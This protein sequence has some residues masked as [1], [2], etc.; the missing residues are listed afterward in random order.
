M[1][2]DTD[3]TYELL[4]AYL[5]GELD[6]PEIRRVEDLLQS[7]PDA[8]RQFEELLT[9]R[10]ALLETNAPAPIGLAESIIAKARFAPRQKLPF[11]RIAFFA[12]SLLIVLSASFFVLNDKATLDRKVTAHIEKAKSGLDLDAADDPYIETEQ[13]E[14][15]DDGDR[16]S[17]TEGG[18]TSSNR[19]ED[20]ERIIG[21]K[22]RSASEKLLEKK[23]QKDDAIGAPADKNVEVLKDDPQ[24]DS[25]MKTEEPKQEVQE[26]APPGAPNS[27]APAKTAVTGSAK[28]TVV[29]QPQP[30]SKP[31]SGAG[32][33]SDA[34]SSDDKSI[35]DDGDSVTKPVARRGSSLPEWGGIAAISFNSQ[36]RLLYLD[37]AL[38]NTLVFKGG[39]AT[40]KAYTQISILIPYFGIIALEPNS[41]L[42]VSVVKNGEFVRALPA[43]TLESY[44]RDYE[45][46]IVV[47]S[48]NCSF[49]P[50]EGASSV[51]SEKESLKLAF[52][53][54]VIK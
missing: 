46:H 16:S 48:G 15:S 21:G 30:T 44:A 29:A 40:I 42:I 53:G 38:P 25:G 34:M 51:L 43:L 37:S 6:A 13:P 5:D 31:K 39:S 9:V 1:T 45:V 17:W 22:K 12:A 20:L 52:K 36:E 27:P 18:Y 49:K 33:A 2:H 32:K 47:T 14:Y 7:D 4:L 24:Q 11:V 23:Q 26:S 35:A 8:A 3:N 54:A 41:I 19:F 50:I 10:S 28:A